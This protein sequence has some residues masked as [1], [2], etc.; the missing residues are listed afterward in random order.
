MTASAVLLAADQG[1]LLSPL[2]AF[3]VVICLCFLLCLVAGVANDT[4][5]DFWTAERS[6]PALRN[7]LALCGDYLPA[8]A[9]LS[10]VGTVAL[11]G[12]DGMATAASAAAST[13]VLLVLAEPLRNTGRFTLGSVLASRAP[14]PAGR[15]ARIA[16]AV[17][18]LAVCVPLAVVQLRVAG[19][20]TAYVLGS[21]TPGAALVCTVLSGLLI[22]TFAAFGGMRG[23]GM[24]QTGKTLL[25]LGVVVA[26]AVAAGGAL[27]WDFD[28]LMDRSAIGGGG[29]AVFHAPGLL[30]G[31][32]APGPLEQFSLC[33]TVALGSAVVPP[34]LM[35]VG[36]S[37]DGRAARRATGCAAA[38]ISVFYG[39]VVLLGL[40]AAAV[41]GVRG[42][43]TDDPQ[44][45]SALLLLTDALAHGAGGRVLFT[46]VACAVFVTALASVA[47]LTLAGAAAL[48]HDLHTGVLRRGRSTDRRELAAAQWSIVAVGVVAVGLAVLLRGW[49]ILFLASFAAAAAA[50]VILPALLYTLFWPGFSR[51]GMLWTLHGS[52]ACCVLL[53]L[54]GPTVSGQPYSLLP[55]V[56]FHWFPLQNIAVATVPVGFLLGWAGSRLRPPTP[57]E[58]AAC[59]AAETAVLVGRT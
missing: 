51:L 36:A 38:V 57:A 39:L 30:F 13:A 35:R 50:S 4:A 40:A 19:E 47:G 15:A 55:G 23:T 14:G 53:Q 31:P 42:I 12:Y 41:V 10:P 54:F 8:T 58:R 52:L 22:T 32:G 33:L 25:V 29:A 5:A 49:S 2:T 34:L 9:L 48:S 7:A 43:A 11:A 16:G 46:A 21:R 26:L 45:N 24:I 17:T 1:S 6:M 20:A 59:T 37:L 44:G 28:A 3:L 18:T 27:H 56:D